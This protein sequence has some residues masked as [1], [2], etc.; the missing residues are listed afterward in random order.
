VITSVSK[1]PSIYDVD[2]SG[3]AVGAELIN[4]NAQ[5]TIISTPALIKGSYRFDFH[6]HITSAA[7]RKVSI[8]IRNAADDADIASYTIH[9]QIDEDFHF[10]FNHPVPIEQGYLVK[11]RLEENVANGDAQGIISWGRTII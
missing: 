2:N 9:A 10:S 6:F 7:S 3:F 11:I 5:D 8:V 4:P 1:A